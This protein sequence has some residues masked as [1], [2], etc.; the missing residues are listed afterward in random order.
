MIERLSPAELAQLTDGL[1]QTAAQIRYLREIGIRAER[2]RA[3]GVLVLRAWLT[4]DCRRVHDSGE[5]ELV[6]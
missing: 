3:G 6:D 4:Q 1:S 2:T 5:P